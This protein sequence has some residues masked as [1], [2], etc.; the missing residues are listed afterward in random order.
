MDGLK[1]VVDQSGADFA[2]QQCVMA[3]LRPIFGND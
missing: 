1:R 2:L 3:S